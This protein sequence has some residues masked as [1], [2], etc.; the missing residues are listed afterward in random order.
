MNILMLR[1]DHWTKWSPNW[2]RLLLRGT[3]WTSLLCFQFIILIW[4]SST[5][6]DCCSGYLPFDSSLM[7]GMSWREY[8][9]AIHVA[10]FSFMFGCWAAKPLKKMA[11][12]RS[13]LINSDVSDVL[14]YWFNHLNFWNHN[15]LTCQADGLRYHW[16]F[17][18]ESGKTCLTPQG[19][20]PQV[21]N[22]ITVL[23]AE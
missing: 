16:A 2:G 17:E 4:D 19:C 23:D 21:R 5:K 18:P 1:L 12:K 14:Q 13:H 8:W 10:L 22:N 20:Q 3:G 15:S 11:P 6:L 7:S 9:K